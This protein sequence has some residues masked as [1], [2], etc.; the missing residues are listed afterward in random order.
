MTEEEKLQTLQN[1]IH[2]LMGRIVILQHMVTRLWLNTMDP[3]DALEEI[4]KIPPLA[5]D[6]PD[7]H[8][9]TGYNLALDGMIGTI[10][11]H[12]DSDPTED[13]PPQD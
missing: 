13:H 9:E 2:H 7:L 8:M 4:R 3:Q 12:L 10:R 1:E 11:S 5:F 6:P